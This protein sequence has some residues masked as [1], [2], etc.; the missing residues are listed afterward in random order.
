MEIFV[1]F[2][3]IFEKPTLPHI[4]YLAFLLLVTW[5]LRKDIVFWIFTLRKL[6]IL[7]GPHVFPITPNRNH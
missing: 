4:T 7:E 6:L 5:Y 2:L 3:L 1:Q